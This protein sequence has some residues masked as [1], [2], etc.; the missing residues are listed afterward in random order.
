VNL[1]AF[2]FDSTYYQSLKNMKVVFF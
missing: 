1:E 2:I